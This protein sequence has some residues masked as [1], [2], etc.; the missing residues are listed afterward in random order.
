MRA[1]D[2]FFTLCVDAGVAKCT[3]EVPHLP[4]I[5]S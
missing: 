5:I 1:S 2:E 3:A 4:L